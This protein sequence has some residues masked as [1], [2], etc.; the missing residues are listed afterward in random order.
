MSINKN[1]SIYLK[2]FLFFRHDNSQNYLPP[3]VQKQDVTCH[4]SLNSIVSIEQY[5]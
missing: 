4:Q 1:I 5:V 3:L 2:F